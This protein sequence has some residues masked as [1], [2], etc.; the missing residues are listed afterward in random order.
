MFGKA[1]FRN[2]ITR[3]KC[4]PKNYTRK[5][6]GNVADFILFYTKTDRYVWNRPIEAWTPERALKEYKY[7]TRRQA[8]ATRRSRCMHPECE[9]VRRGNPGE[10]CFPSR[11]ALAVQAFDARRTR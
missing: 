5:A 2:L 10:A 9:M 6:F 11:Q 3:K 8:G 7:L 4:N 1:Q